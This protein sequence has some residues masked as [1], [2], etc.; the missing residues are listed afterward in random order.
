MSATVIPIVT[1]EAVLPHNVGRGERGDADRA[2]PHPAW[3]GGT[4]VPGWTRG[5]APAA[6]PTPNR[7]PDLWLY[8]ER[9]VAMLRRY[10]RLSVETGRLPSLLGREFFRA[11]ITSYQMATF[12]DAVIFVHDV[13]SS[14]A[15][16]DDFSQQLIARMVLQEYTQE[17]AARLLGCCRQTLSQRYF[18]AL[19][20]VTEI[21]LTTGMV[22]PL[23]G[24]RAEAGKACQEGE[25]EESRVSL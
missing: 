17:E 9:T 11:R 7:D 12:E 22:E 19:D 21:F 20:R 1:A 15:K 10:L 8:R 4:P 5:V 25:S 14:L 18:E 6:T 2:A 13:E 24:A 16:L 23:P 3:V